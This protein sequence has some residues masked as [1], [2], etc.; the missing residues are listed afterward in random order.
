MMTDVRWAA[1]TNEQGV[2][3]VAVR[4][5]LL[6]VGARPHEQFLLKDKSCC[7]TFRLRPLSGEL[8]APMALARK[9]LGVGN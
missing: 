6:S 8:G 7:Y 2:G 5:P 4:D 1:L 3:L 9:S